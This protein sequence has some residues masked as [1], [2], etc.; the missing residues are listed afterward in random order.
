MKAWPTLVAHN[1]S[2]AFRPGQPWSITTATGEFD[3]P[4]ADEREF[5]MGYAVGSTAAPGVSEKQ[6]RAVLGESMDSHCM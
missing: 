2:Y 1:H 6:R 3:Q 4:T 5:A